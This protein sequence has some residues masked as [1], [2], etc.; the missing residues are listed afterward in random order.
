MFTPD[1]IEAAGADNAEGVFISGPDLTAL[2]DADFY[3]NDFLPAYQ[4]KFGEEPQSVFHAHSFDA[5]NLVADAIEEVGFDDGGTFKIPRTALKDALFAVEGSPGI[6]GNFTCDE[7]G[8]CLPCATMS[9]QVVEGG[10]F[11]D[12]IYTEELCLEG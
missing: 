6:V 9:V 11:S 7:N 1:W 12:P 3:E 4:E 2:A 10:D 5:M 8:D